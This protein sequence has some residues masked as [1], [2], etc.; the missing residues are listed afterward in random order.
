MTTSG[1]SQVEQS[2]R[3]P[4]GPAPLRFVTATS[5]FDGHDAAINVMR[6]LIQA[7]GAEVVHLGHNRSVEDIV[8]AA[9]QEDADGVAVSSYQGGHLEYFKYMLDM[10]RKRGAAHVRVFGGGGGTITPD[11]IAELERYGVERIYHPD[12]GM[13]LGLV[14]MIQDLA[15]R[16]RTAALARRTHEAALDFISDA[17][18]DIDDEIAIGRVL[19]LIE[20][21]RY[22][23][24]DAAAPQA[25]RAAG[26]TPVL[27]VTG[28]GG[29]GKS[30]VVDELLLRLLRARPDMRVAV[31]AVDPTR[32]RTG[33]ALLGDRIRMNVL[34]SRRVFMRSMAT[35]RQN[36]ATSSVLKDC[37]C[38]LRQVG[39]NLIIVETA[40]IGQ[41]DSGIVDL[42][43][44]SIYVMTSD[45]GA[46]S[47]LEKIDML[48]FADL[49]VLNKFDRRG[50]EDALRDVR[51]QWK[52]NRTAF[53]LS[54]DEIPVYPTIAS[55]FNDPGVTWM[56]VNLC[57]LLREKLG[58]ASRDWSPQ[59]DVSVREPRA[60]ALIP[61][62]RLLYL[63]D[64]AE[65]GRSINSDIDRQVEAATRAQAY[66]QALG[67]IDDGK[68][69]D[70]LT[71]YDN[72]DLIDERSD[73]SLLTLRQRYQGAVT[74]LSPEAVALLRE[75]PARF[76]SITDSHYTYEVRDRAVQGDNYVESLSHQRIP[77]I[78]A[79]TFR[80]WGELLRFLMRENLPGAYPYTAGVYPYRRAGEDP[81][82]MFAGEGTPERT[83]RRF[84]SLAAGQKAVRL[85]TAFDSVTLYG[86]DP[87]S[88]PDIYG[89]VGNSG[90]SI[91]TL[92]DMKKLYSGFDLSDPATS[93]SM[94]INGPAPII[95]AMFLN[96]AV[97]QAVEQYL[98]Q[99]SKRWAAAQARIAAIYD[100]H[101]R[102]RYEGRLPD[103]HSGLGLELLGVSGDQ[104]VEPHLY[105]RIQ[106]DTLKVVR[107]TVQADILKEDQAQNTCIFSTEFALRMMGDVQ[108]YFIDHGVRNFYSVSI[109]GYHIAEAG[110]NA[111]T[112]LA[113]T[114]ANGFTLVEYYLAR[115][116]TIDDFAPN[117]SF[118]FSNGM[119]PEY[120]VIGRV[121]RRIWARATR[122]RYRANPRSQMLKYHVQTSGRSLH[123]QEIQFNDIRTT[124][125]A[126]YALFDN[127]NSLHTNAYDEAVTTP[128]EE[129]VRRAVAIQLIINRE[130]GMN[131]CEN[132]WQGSFIIE[133]LTDIVEE[134][135]YK[136]FEAISERGGVLG[137]MDTTYQRGK[138]QEESLYYEQ[139]KHDGT[140]P[141]IGVNTFQLKTH[142]GR[143][144]T[145]GELVRSNEAEK[146]RQIRNVEAFRTV[147]NALLPGNGGT[148]EGSLE[149]L[150]QTARARQNTFATLVEVV[151]YYSLGQISHAL[152]EVGG[153][154]RRNM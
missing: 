72:E 84:H 105:G 93:V 98:R 13:R 89:K 106:A 81:I 154:Y 35:R 7:E 28:T 112:Q 49:V 38:F 123:A 17:I 43:D 134:A 29:A 75:W 91:A 95:L 109:S 149:Q 131:F 144:A 16:T 55:Q 2:F 53:T 146:Q 115:G 63:A 30:S 42:V 20:A 36:A 45:Y 113:F 120:S 132:P 104:L 150:Q 46:A 60:T 25:D 68:C 138:I 119:D 47:Q 37:V 27:G 50:V 124:L 86:E 8:R 110:A 23:T 70:A 128:T 139:K 61:G 59:V 122:E 74:A 15:H 82:R 141:L 151:K 52:R 94:T 88:R 34:R 117:L 152:Y 56:F 97:D 31:L 87:H 80:D 6:R 65:L 12:D 54:D 101:E 24:G 99:D 76:K 142:S 90:V 107:G 18:P 71:L 40:G 83:N 127:C 64:I 22:R 143:I 147:R 1:D 85:S 69:P 96:V 111:I 126:L 57:R 39:Y 41:G 33:G 78:A 153:E 133:K 11:E 48:D 136:E 130:L 121:A 118:F 51:K 19:S 100:Q 10:L 140:L 32:R 9:L 137:A 3:P 135:V 21:G 148:H 114:L 66:W 73:R 79:P 125:Q 58:L 129:S 145:V 103:G 77:K 102:P 67:E 4:G 5:L 116:M 108:H 62:H 26:R 44:F 92:D 14:A